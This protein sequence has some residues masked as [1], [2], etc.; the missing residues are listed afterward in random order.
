MKPLTANTH[1][2]HDFHPDDDVIACDVCG[3]RTYNDEAKQPCQEYL[4]G[5]F[6]ELAKDR[7]IDPPENA[8]AGEIMAAILTFD[9][10]ALLALGPEGD[11]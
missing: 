10:M 11:G 2:S 1:P 4:R 3:C 5:A 9:G 7:G 8:T 6:V